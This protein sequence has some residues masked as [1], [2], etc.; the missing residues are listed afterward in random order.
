MSHEIPQ[1][2]VGFSIKRSEKFVPVFFTKDVD[3]RMTLM[4]EIIEDPEWSM[5]SGPLDLEFSNLIG[6][7][8][9]IKFEKLPSL[10]T[11]TVSLVNL[12]LE[13]SEKEKP[14]DVL[15][16]LD[17]SARNEAYFF[18]LFWS[19]LAK[20]G[21]ISEDIKR[22]EIR[23]V[24]IG[25][26]TP[27]KMESKSGLALLKAITLGEFN[28]K[29]VIILD[30][31]VNTG[32]SLMTAGNVIKDVF[33]ID[34][35]K[36]GIFNVCPYWYDGS[37]A[38]LGVMDLFVPEDLKKILDE[39]EPDDALKLLKYFEKISE[40]EFEEI[41]L[42][43]DIE[44]IKEGVIDYNSTKLSSESNLKQ[45]EILEMFNILISNNLFFAGQGKSSTYIWEYIM[46]AGGY[47]SL[48][49]KDEDLTREHARHRLVL[50][51][52]V[53]KWMLQRNKSRRF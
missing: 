40:N 19:E 29:K 13:Q 28:D 53:D 34:A 45:K 47:L 38:V 39:V 31:F 43:T 49:F 27:K 6:G 50:K 1:I 9:E 25:Q 16:F 41:I 22:P 30:E 44:R 10:L 21:E 52:I 37:P 23:F 5:G 32:G 11:D 18:R 51:M 3:K 42:S 17:K 7:A 8:D 33:G 2:D 20:R 35:L 14:V 36:A 48:S 15:L 46:S 4:R 24:N 12:V 26:E